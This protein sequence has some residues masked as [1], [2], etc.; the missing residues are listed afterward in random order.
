MDL[1]I[2]EDLPEYNNVKHL[3][4]EKKVMSDLELKEYSPEQTEQPQ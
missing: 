1:F 4:T 3:F 2:R